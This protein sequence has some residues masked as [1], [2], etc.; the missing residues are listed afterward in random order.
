MKARTLLLLLPLLISTALAASV[1]FMWQKNQPQTEPISTSLREIIAPQPLR[2]PI[3]PE[4]SWLDSDK[5]IVATNQQRVANRLPA[6]KP[7]AKLSQAATKKA[8]DMFARQYFEHESPDGR[9]P[10]DLADS[11]N[12]AF[13]RVGENLA[14]GNFKSEEELVQAWMDS[15]GHRENILHTGFSEIGISAI[16][17][18]FE[19]SQVWMSVQEFA[20]PLSS[21]PQPDNTLREKAENLQTLYNTQAKDLEIQALKLKTLSEQIEAER[22][23][24]ENSEEINLPAQIEAFNKKVDQ[25]NT[26]RESHLA[27]I[28]EQETLEKQLKSTIEELNSQI[29]TFNTCLEK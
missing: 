12:Y 15:P 25:Y 6:L 13:I 16:K 9:G 11:V 28:K 14:S 3:S 22:K 26:L 8:Q 23:A 24:I 7:S 4:S 19:G 1:I 21:C 18:T 29:K 20:L 2:L 5:I 10:G 27:K 17:G